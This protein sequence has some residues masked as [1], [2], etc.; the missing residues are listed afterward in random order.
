MPQL[1]AARAHR[2]TISDIATLAAAD[3][4]AALVSLSGEPLARIGAELR[5]V[6][7]AIADTY[8]AAAALVSA[9]YYMNQRAAAKIKGA[10]AFT[11]TLKSSYPV[12]KTLEG[13]IGY[14][15][16]RIAATPEVVTLAGVSAL[17][18]NLQRVIAGIDR[19]LIGDNVALD[20]VAIRYQRLASATACGFCILIAVQ[21]EWQMQEDTGGFHDSCQCVNVPIFEGQEFQKPDY[22]DDWEKGTSASYDFADQA[23]DIRKYGVGNYLNTS[24]DKGYKDGIWSAEQDRAAVQRAAAA[25]KRK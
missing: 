7:P 24:P 16:S 9:D 11:P 19:A 2:K 1:Q 17:T 5:Q 20:P 4:S 14:T 3:A 12:A 13:G 18:G 10:Q 8:G 23:A 15:L 6:V 25:I 21:A 22:W